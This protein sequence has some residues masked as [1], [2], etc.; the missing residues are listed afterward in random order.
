MRRGLLRVLR[1]FRERLQR[2]VRGQPAAA[3]PT[4]ELFQRL[5]AD[6]PWRDVDH[7]LEGDAIERVVDESQVG[8]DIFDLLALVEARAADETIFDLLA[9]ERL[10]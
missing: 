7:A 6:A 8:E 5:R 1:R 4:P 3:G 10:L 2:R 9:D